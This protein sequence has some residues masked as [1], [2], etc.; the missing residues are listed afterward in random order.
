MTDARRI[1][2]RE[3]LA[4]SLG[5]GAASL[6]IHRHLW[7]AEAPVDPDRFVLLSDVHICQDAQKVHLGAE[8]Y[9]NFLR[10][11]REY[12]ALDTRPAGLI[13][14][15]DAAFLRGEKGD[16]ERLKELVAPIPLPLTFAMGNH[17]HRENFWSVFPEHQ[18]QPSPVD[19]RHVLVLETPHADWIILDSLDQTD[20]IP[21]SMGETQ[22]NWLAAELD[23]R[24]DKP[25][26]LVGHHYP[27]I[28]GHKAALPKYGLLDTAAFYEVILPRKRVKAYIYGHSHHWEVGQIE[29]VHLVNLATLVWV[30]VEGDPRGWVDARL[31]PDGLRLTLQCLDPTHKAHGRPVDLAWR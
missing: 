4:A 9:P 13:L 21:G 23:R 2:R 25:A 15:G 18:V 11:R 26:I 24:P 7:S 1:S 28:E 29:G 22:L 8:P 31:R 3:L 10:A 6:L 16:Y 27:V 17:D 5:A 12:L 19:G 30:F 14:S 20:E